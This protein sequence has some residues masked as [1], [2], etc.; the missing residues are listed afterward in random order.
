MNIQGISMN[1]FLFEKLGP[2]GEHNDYAIRFED[3]QDWDR[4]HIWFDQSAAI[5]EIIAQ[6]HKYGQSMSPVIIIG[7]VGTGKNIVANELYKT[8]FLNKD[9]FIRQKPLMIIDCIL[10]TSKKWKWILEHSN[11]PFME[12]GHIIYIKNVEVLSV[13]FIKQM[14]EYF[15][16]GA[17]YSHNKII[18]SYS[19]RNSDD[20]PDEICRLFANNLGCLKLQLPTLRSRKESIPNLIRLC[21]HEMNETPEKARIDFEAE[22]VE[23]MRDF[24]WEDNL[25]QLKRVVEELAL[26]AMGSCI[27]KAEV[28]ATLKK[29]SQ[30]PQRSISSINMNQTLDDIMKD[31]IL[32]VLQEENMNQS[33]A[34]KRLGIGRSTM[35]RK[36]NGN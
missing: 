17:V 12:I 3:E 8:C 25:E 5:E 35:W 22:A 28:A 6:I 9:H 21:R 18:F 19:C 15:K 2:G 30:R 14:H 20:E 7:E 32:L 24:Y 10:M 33:K 13:S 11:S 4:D 29:E 1:L 36:L 31:I 34:A 23:L 26:N 27:T 16:D